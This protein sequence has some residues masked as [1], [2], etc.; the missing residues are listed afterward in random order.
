VARSYTP[1]W[2]REDGDDVF[3]TWRARLVAVPIICGLVGLLWLDH[4]L[5]DSTRLANVIA[6]LLDVGLMFCAWVL[7]LGRLNNDA[8]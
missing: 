5:F 7:V 4:L 1:R 3:Y 2:Y 6:T 8:N